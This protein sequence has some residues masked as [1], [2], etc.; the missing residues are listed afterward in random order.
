MGIIFI[1]L[2]NEAPK[3]DEFISPLTKRW[4]TFLGA[5][6]LANIEA[7]DGQ[8]RLDITIQANWKLAVENYCEAY[9]LPW[10]H[11]SLNKYSPINKH[12]NIVFTEN[13][14]GQGSYAYTLSDVAG[15]ALP[16]FENWPQD[17]L[18]HAEYI[19][20]YPNVLLG[21]QVDHAFA[22]VLQ[23]VSAGV[24]IEKLQLLYVGEEAL[25]EPF[26]DSREAVLESWRQVFSEDIFVV[27]G[28]Q[29]ARYSPGFTGG[30]FSAVMDVPSHHFHQWVAERYRERSDESG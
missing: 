19:S 7:P 15:T 21:L 25:D 11:P 3:F 14:S 24:T 22:M 28:M 26:K 2:S 6:G 23:P 18:K 20:L 9:H 10:V 8:S 4:E 17:K 12:Y 13:M 29:K 30:V 16:Q 27:E 5:E 1:N